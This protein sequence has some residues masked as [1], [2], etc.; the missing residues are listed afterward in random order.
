MYLSCRMVRGIETRNKP[1]SKDTFH[2][3]F[4]KM[5]R[6]AGTYLIKF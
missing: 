1:S 4:E 5:D 3:L 6:I 2:L